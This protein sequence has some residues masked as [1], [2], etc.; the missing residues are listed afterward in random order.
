MASMTAMLRAP[1]SAEQRGAAF[2]LRQALDTIGGVIGPLAA[3]LFL[4]GWA[5]LREQREAAAPA[6]V[7]ED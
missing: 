3:G 6:P 4:A 2:G 5:I 7:P 1:S